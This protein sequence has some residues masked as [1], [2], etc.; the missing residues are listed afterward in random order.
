MM[1]C[2]VSLKAIK[3]CASSRLWGAVGVGAQRSRLATNRTKALALS[4]VM[5]KGSVSA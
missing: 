5:G 3:F 4:G 1:T 2:G